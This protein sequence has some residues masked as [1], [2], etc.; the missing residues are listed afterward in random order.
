MAQGKQGIWMSIFPDGEN[1]GNLATTQGKI[2]N[3]GE[4]LA[5]LIPNM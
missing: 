1:T 5:C 2:E 3:T 4:K